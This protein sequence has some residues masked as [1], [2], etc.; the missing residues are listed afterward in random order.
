MSEC[1]YQDK[2]V[3]C[4]PDMGHYSKYISYFNLLLRECTIVVHH[5]LEMEPCLRL[6]KINCSAIKCFFMA[7]VMPK[8]MRGGG[9]GRCGCG[10]TNMC[11]VRIYHFI[12]HFTAKSTFGSSLIPAFIPLGLN[13]DRA[14]TQSSVLQFVSGI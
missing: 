14:N 9:G 7:S 4:N 11:R 2:L 3:D 8:G 5:S 1:P 6:F 13:T 10:G 12:K